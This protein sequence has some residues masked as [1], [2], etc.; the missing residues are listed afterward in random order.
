MFQSSSRQT[1]CPHQA[2]QGLGVGEELREAVDRQQR[3]L[4][5]LEAGPLEPSPQIGLAT[6]RAVV[7]EE[8][9]P[10]L[11]GSFLGSRLSPWLIPF[12]VDV[13]CCGKHAPNYSARLSHPGLTLSLPGGKT[14]WCAFQLC[15]VFGSP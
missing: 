15:L 8:E 7:A 3:Q 12:R 4:T 5:D 6:P 10:F 2:Q 13:C 1:T 11:R 9:P 14:G